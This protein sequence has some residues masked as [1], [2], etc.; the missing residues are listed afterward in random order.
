MIE[1]L[2]VGEGIGREDD[3]EREGATPISKSNSNIN[4]NQQPQAA[5]PDAP[6]RSCH[7]AVDQSPGTGNEG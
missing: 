2:E 5:R 4:S 1:V 3:R 6:V 7:H